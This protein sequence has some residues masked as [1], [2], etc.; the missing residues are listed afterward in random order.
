MH[1][2]CVEERLRRLH[3][4]PSPREVAG[5]VLES[6]ETGG[7][8]FRTGG[9]RP[10]LKLHRAVHAVVAECLELLGQGSDHV[11]HVDDDHGIGVIVDPLL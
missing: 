3:P 1:V 6:V 11:K 2:R 4:F 8:C 10:P 9:G 7:L 5:H